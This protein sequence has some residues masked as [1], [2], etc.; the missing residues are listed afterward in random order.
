MLGP[1][2]APPKVI[3]PFDRREHHH[4]KSEAHG[5]GVKTL[6]ESTCLLLS[7]VLAPAGMARGGGG[8][9]H[10]VGEGAEHQ[11]SGRGGPS[12][13]NWGLHPRVLAAQWRLALLLL[14][15]GERANRS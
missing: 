14:I 2:R 15:Q 4:P 9:G 6:T 7:L 12:G 10:R 3:T 13:Q 11:G 1:H 5:E 8:A